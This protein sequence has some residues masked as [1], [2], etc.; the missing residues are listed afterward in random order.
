MDAGILPWPKSTST[1]RQSCRGDERSDSTLANQNSSRFQR[2][3]SRRSTLGIQVAVATTTASVTAAAPA[4]AAVA[5]TA[6][7]S[8]ERAGQFGK[9][10]M[11]AFKS[12]KLV[13]Y[14]F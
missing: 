1:D 13:S 10:K 7:A 2:S 5:A 3:S 14:G 12:I 6:A 4:T 11:V 8:V 9:S